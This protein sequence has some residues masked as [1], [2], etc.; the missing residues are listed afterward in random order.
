V[1]VLIDFSD[2]VLVRVRR[3]SV[4]AR[5]ATVVPMLVRG[6]VFVAA[7]AALVTAYPSS[8]ALGRGLGLLMIVAVL[9]AV[10]PRGAFASVVVV[11]AVGGW[12]LATVPYAEPVTFWRLV[13]LAGALYL[14]HSLTALAAVLPHDAIVEPELLVRWLSRALVIVVASAVVAL[15]LLVAAAVAGGEPILV[16][17]LVGFGVAVGLARLLAVLPRR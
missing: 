6:G 15:P 17:S 10:A 3:I 8:I 7:L 14:G 12:L 13:A 11:V 5:R 2:G 16:V 4:A 9:P 1:T